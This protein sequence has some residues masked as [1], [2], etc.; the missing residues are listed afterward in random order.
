MRGEKQQTS[1]QTRQ[2]CTKQKH[3]HSNIPPLNAFSSL[4][5]DRLTEDSTGQVNQVGSLPVVPLR[6]AAHQGR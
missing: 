6:L 1:T 4:K 2:K 5:T 3:F